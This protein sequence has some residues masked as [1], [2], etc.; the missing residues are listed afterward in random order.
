MKVIE[1]YGLLE[2]E[3]KVDILSENECI[4]NDTFVLELSEPFPGYYGEE[5]IKKEKPEMVFL[6]LN[7]D[8]TKDDIFR[9]T[10]KIKNTSYICFD[11]TPCEI[12]ISKDEFE[13]IRIRFIKSY[14]LI[15]LIQERYLQEGINFMKKKNV[16]GKAFIKVNKIFRIEEI[17]EDIYRDIDDENIY[18]FAIPCK[19]NW[20]D[21]VDVTK[22]VRNNILGI[23]FDAALGFVYY[24]TITDIIRIYSKK[25]S[26]SDLNCIKKQ[27]CHE[28]CRNI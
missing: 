27:Y 1:T 14:E 10:K 7:T 17:F 12:V 23:S 15:K 8:H 26:V 18:Y 25:I 20:S 3:E 6:I 9:I 16:K 22:R 19:L 21:F 13:A 24:N 11:A 5:F 2:K 28:I 4:L